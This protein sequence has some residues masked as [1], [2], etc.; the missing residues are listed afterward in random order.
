MISPILEFGHS[1]EIYHTLPPVSYAHL[2]LENNEHTHPYDSSPSDGG[3]GDSSGM[4]RT[5]AAMDFGEL[6][7]QSLVET[8]TA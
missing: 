4:E 1:N 3:S 8:V 5:S 7:K 2:N 6:L